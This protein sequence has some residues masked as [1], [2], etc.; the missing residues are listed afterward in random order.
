MTL[1]SR[2]RHW[3]T[4]IL[5]IAG[6][7]SLAGMLGLCE[8][9]MR[10]MSHRALSRRDNDAASVWATRAARI[11]DQDPETAFLLARLAR[12]RGQMEEMT[13]WL[14]RAAALGL[15]RDRIR[16]EETLALAQ[17]GTLPDPEQHLPP[18]LMEQQGDGREICEAFANGFLI[19]GRFA[20]ATSLIH[21]WRQAYPQDSL[22]D[23][24]LG[25]ISEF[26][27][28][29]A[30]GESHY[31]DALRKNSADIKAAYGLGRVLMDLNRLPDA[32][33]QFRRGL[34]QPMREPFQFALAR[35]LILLGREEESEEHLRTVAAVPRDR[36]NQAFQEVGEP[37][38]FDEVRL[39]LGRLEMNR[40]H[41]DEAIR[42]FQQAVDYNP[43]HRQARYRL[44]T[45]LKTAGRNDEAKPHF[46]FY[47]KVQSK[48]AEF[49]RLNDAVEA[50]PKDAEAR[51]QLGIL[52]LEMDSTETGL[53][54]LR[55]ALSMNPN[56]SLARAA[57]TAHVQQQSAS[58][59]PVS[60]VA[61]DHR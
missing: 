2:K 3:L 18:L 56:H 11:N 58:K 10:E 28:L 15:D 42:W 7:L 55:S 8:W 54:W 17:T 49:D 16:R 45:A 23:V 61:N 33:D 35:C 46:D 22:P 50:D 52:C 32:A 34:A 31:R 25:R 38:E 51:Y 1:L 6:A 41:S 12:K 53:F 60:A 57:L 47:T 59:L 30:E 39:E 48:F 19:H 21:Q 14:K 9:V 24:L 13:R 27:H 36:L 29:P 5:V 40:G 43:R 44:A 26:D 4:G 37:T 20:E